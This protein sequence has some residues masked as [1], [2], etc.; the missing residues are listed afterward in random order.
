MRNKPA[1]D[2]NSRAYQEQRLRNGRSSLLAILLF[3]VINLVFLL[4]DTG[5]YFLFSASVPYY[6]TWFGKVLDNGTYDGSGTVIGT[7]TIT[8]VVVS[9]II[10]AVYLV[11]WL[12]SKKRQGWLTVGAVLFTVDTVALAVFA[13]CLLDNPASCLL[14]LI[15][16]AFALWSL[17]SATRAAKKLKSMP[18]AASFDSDGIKGTTPDLP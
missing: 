12:L 8:A 16:H 10:L 5:R 2:K 13:F 18:E 1:V 15:F 17:F 4:L 9:L 6:L 7:F 11:I 3:S 14:D